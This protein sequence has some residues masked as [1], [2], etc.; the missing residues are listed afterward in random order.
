MGGEVGFEATVRESRERARRWRGRRPARGAGSS[1]ATTRLRDR[2]NCAIAPLQWIDV[3]PTLLVI[4]IA[5]V[6]LFIANF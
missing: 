4:A 2:A 1:N 6:V 3:A 5:I